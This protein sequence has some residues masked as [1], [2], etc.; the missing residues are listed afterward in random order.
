MTKPADLTLWR[1]D[2]NPPGVAHIEK[3][4]DESWVRT[5][6]HR[7][8]PLS[9]KP[10]TATVPEDRVRRGSRVCRSCLRRLPTTDRPTTD[11]P[12]DDTTTD[13]STPEIE[14]GTR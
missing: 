12:T 5:W 1:L 8:L 3:D 4:R 13:T 10:M 2:R 11:R 6:C 14:G 7:W 9:D